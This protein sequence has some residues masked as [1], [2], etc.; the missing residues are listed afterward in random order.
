MANPKVRPF[1][2]D[3]PR[4]AGP[5][6]SEACEAERWLHDVP[7][8]LT[9]PMARIGSSDFYIHEP[10]MLRNAQCVIPVRWFNKKDDNNRLYAHCWEM[11]TLTTDQGSGWRVTKSKDLVVCATELLKNFP[12]LCRD[13]GELYSLPDPTSILGMSLTPTYS[14]CLYCAQMYM[15]RTTILTALGCLRRLK[16]ITPT[17]GGCLQEARV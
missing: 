5:Q 12:E 1:L 9:T 10:A 8:D 17:D 13:S 3:Y 11:S 2:R 6:V 4:D 15:I 16:T 14:A 7:D